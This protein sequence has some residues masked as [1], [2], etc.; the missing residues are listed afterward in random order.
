MKYRE[1]IILGV[2][3]FLGGFLR[4]YNLSEN[5][6]GFF[7]DEASIGYNAYLLFKNGRDEYGQKFPL[8]FRS[9]GDYKN[10]VLIYSVIPSVALF[11][12]SEFAVRIVPAI[13]GS[14]TILIIY[15]LGKKLFGTPVGIFSSLF[16]AISPWH[17][18]LSRMATEGMIA[19]LFFLSLSVYLFFKGQNKTIFLYLSLLSFGLTLYTYYVAYLT[20]PLFLVYLIIVF[21]SWHKFKTLFLGLII[22]S[23][24]STPLLLHISSGKGF[25]RFRQTSL[26]SSKIGPHEIV[27]KI[28]KLYLSHFSLNFLF[29]YGDSN[30]PGQFITRHSIVGIGELYWFQFP[31]LLIGI[32]YLW[33]RRKENNSL[34]IFFWLFIYPLGTV[35]TNAPGPQA[36][37]SIIGVVPFQIVSALGLQKLWILLERYPKTKSF[38]IIL[39]ITVFL[40]S[41][42]YFLFCHQ[43]YPLYSSDYW[44]WQYGPR[45]IIRY[46]KEVETNY[47]ELIMSSN[48]NAGEIFFKFYY[49]EG[50]IKCRIGNI[51]NYNPTKKQIFALSPHEIENFTFKTQK[52]IYYPN[53]E[54]AFL[55]GEIVK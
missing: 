49:P 31:L 22:F 36:T 38:F 54:I 11:G 34:L 21:K 42:L 50:C 9:F 17:V 45:E 26:F 39:V 18:H 25:A 19:F 53:G 16:L 52:V 15:L 8:F 3:L 10:P 28:I 46:F 55:I 37:R 27:K 35:F 33:K 29:K 7:C 6:K 51:T 43:Q 2:I 40:F 48:F 5:P 24:I 32:F 12:L 44:G 14:L 41:F 20:V 4:I 30:F 47:D 1:I 13:Y 23:L